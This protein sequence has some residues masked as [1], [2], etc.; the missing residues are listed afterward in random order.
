MDGETQGL[1][2][3]KQAALEAFR[4]LG[5]YYRIT[6]G[7]GRWYTVELTAYELTEHA[8]DN[9]DYEPMESIIENIRNSEVVHTMRKYARVT[10][11]APDAH[12][13]YPVV[14]R[15]EYITEERDY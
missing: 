9:E 2:E 13:K 11:S 8:I 6:G 1:Y 10:L 15:V 14:D 5:G 12:Y 7:P 4:K 3:T